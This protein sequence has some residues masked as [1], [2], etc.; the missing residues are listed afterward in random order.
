VQLAGVIDSR[1]LDGEETRRVRD[2]ER[3][4]DREL[5]RRLGILS[6]R[7]E[8]EDGIQIVMP[9]FYADDE[10]AMLLD[11]VVPG[12]G[13]V[14]DVS[15]RFKDLARSENGTAS[16]RLTLGR[17]AARRGPAERAVLARLLAHDLA[18]S[19]RRAA[20]AL[21]RSDVAGARAQ[22]TQ[23]RLLVEGAR[24]GVP[25]LTSDAALTRD[26]TLC[27]RF[28]AALVPGISPAPM[29]DSLRYASRRRLHGEPIA[30]ETQ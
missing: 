26:L 27:A 28:E 23:A 20:V 8:D 25:E 24:S 21:D 11:L 29:A 22:L 16:A 10:H 19:L 9:A 2:V 3:A 7:D 6:D 14:A 15:L 1:R 5:A 30:L 4:I 12:P 17:G 18:R 13:P